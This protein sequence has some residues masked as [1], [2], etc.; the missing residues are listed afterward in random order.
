MEEHLFRHVDLPPGATRLPDGMVPLAQMPR[1]AR[2]GCCCMP[3]LHTER[4][5][6]CC[7]ALPA[8]GAKQLLL[9]PTVSLPLLAPASCLQALRG[10]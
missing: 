6:H 10:V 4:P 2:L 7:S 8:W 1:W 5:L 3:G 9:W